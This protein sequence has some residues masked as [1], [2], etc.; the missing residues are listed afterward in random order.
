MITNNELLDAIKDAM[1]VDY[2][3]DIQKKLDDYDEWDSLA[4][5]SLLSFFHDK[6][7]NIE[8]ENIENANNIKTLLNIVNSR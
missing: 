8:L 7:I 3:L 1:D 5:L 6:N 2:E 4:M